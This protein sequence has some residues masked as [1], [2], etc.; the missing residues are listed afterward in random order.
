MAFK[1]NYGKG[2]FPFKKLKQ[3]EEHTPQTKNPPEEVTPQTKEPKEEK[4]PQTQYP[5]VGATL[6]VTD[7]AGPGMSAVGKILKDDEQGS[8]EYNADTQTW[9]KISDTGGIRTNV[10]TEGTKTKTP[11]VG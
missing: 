2:G 5:K 8:Y 1:M 6:Q 3:N 10:S 11:K 9:T 4:T 7:W